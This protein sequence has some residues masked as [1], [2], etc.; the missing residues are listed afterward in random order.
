[1]RPV[2]IPVRDGEAARS[3]AAFTPASTTR[4]NERLASYLALAYTLAIVYAS[5]SPFSGWRDPGIPAFAFL[6]S[7]WPRYLTRFDVVINFVAYLP[8]G[9]A[10]FVAQ[11][12]R[13]RAYV[14]VILAA[15]PCGALNLLME[16]AQNYLPGR[17]SSNLDLLNNSAGAITGAVLA[18]R[19]GAAP[20]LARRAARLR[21]GWFL[22][23]SYVDVGIALLA[24]WFFSQ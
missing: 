3:R 17:I 22:P 5:L 14:S 24:V 15:L 18:A 16:A 9:F 10:L 4:A 19:A 6:T 12:A 13:E 2:R 11:P 21:T 20:W 8:L 23:G 7:A 1:M